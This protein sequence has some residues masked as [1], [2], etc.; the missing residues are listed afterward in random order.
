M[1]A[2]QAKEVT[3]AAVIGAGFMGSGIAAELALR[4]PQLEG[5]TLWDAQP[6][7]AR[8][9]V[10]RGREV[11]DALVAAGVLQTT[12]AD[13]RL[14][15]LSAADALE[16]A[17]AGAQY[18]AEAVP[19]DLALKQ[20]VFRRLDAVAAP[21]AVLASNTSGFDPAAL[22]EGL[23]HPERVLV[24]H[25]FGPAYLIPAVEVVPHAGTAAWATKTA[26]A[27][28][29]VAGKRP[30]PLGKFVPGFVANRLQQALFREALMLIREGVATPEGIDEVVR[31]SFG[32]RLAALGP[33]T[34]ADFAGLDVYASLA[35][36]VWP[37]LSAEPAS[38]APPQ[39]IAQRTAAGQLGAKSGAGFFEW[40]ADRR[41]EVTARRDA[42]LSRALKD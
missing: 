29:R 16:D 39:E 10:E 2:T 22:A 9:A 31:F 18:V 37:T 24:A 32:P 23:D 4:V 5:V 20:E 19:E 11:A 30:I 17:L 21:D 7:A 33:V 1:P 6:G 35:T 38:D 12:E 36:N 13:A 26:I 34:V 27:V 3:R 40:P 28:L 25:Y 42:A 8:R 41:A 14:A 15:R